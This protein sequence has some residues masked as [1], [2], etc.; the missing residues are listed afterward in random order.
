MTDCTQGTAFRRC[1]N[2]ASPTPD[3]GRDCQH[4]L[5]PPDEVMLVGLSEIRKAFAERNQLRAE[6]AKL[7]RL[8]TRRS[9]QLEALQ[10]AEADRR[11][12][13]WR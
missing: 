1:K 10:R 12:G 8:A 7:R 13:E 2:C 6:V 9:W 4:C 11:Q 5:C 3:D